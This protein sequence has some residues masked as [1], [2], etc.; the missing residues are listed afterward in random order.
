MIEELERLIKVVDGKLDSLPPYEP[1]A[2]GWRTRNAALDKIFEELV[3]EE[4][5]KTWTNAGD[6]TAIR[7]AGIRSTSTCGVTG[8]LGNWKRAARA[9]IELLKGGA[10]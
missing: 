9:K 4:K 6:N 2:D 5:A 8:A 10:E 1:S 3:C 7:L